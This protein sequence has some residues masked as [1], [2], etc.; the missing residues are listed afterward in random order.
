[1][2]IQIEKEVVDGNE[3]FRVTVYL[4]GEDYLSYLVETIEMQSLKYHTKAE[5]KTQ[6]INY[7]VQ[8]IDAKIVIIAGNKA[9]ISW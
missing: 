9:I 2:I 4:N 8:F 5:F 3:L 7:D 6:D 1:M